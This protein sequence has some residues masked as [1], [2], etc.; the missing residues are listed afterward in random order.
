M[1]G[2]GSTLVAAY[3]TAEARDAA[4]NAMEGVR[5]VR[6]ETI[7]AMTALQDIEA[8]QRMSSNS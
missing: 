7:S 5:T 2:S 8:I 6:A 1:T 4:A 3:R